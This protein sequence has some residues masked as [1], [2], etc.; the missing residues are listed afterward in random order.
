MQIFVTFS[1]AFIAKIAHPQLSAPAVPDDA[2]QRIGDYMMPSFPPQPS[3]L[4]FLFETR[5]G[6]PE[7]C[8]AAHALWQQGMFQR[9]LVSGGKTGGHARSEAEFI[10]ERL[11]ALGMP[12]S[13]LILETAATNTGENVLLGRATVAEHMDVES[14]RSVLV[15][16]KVCS[17]RR[18]LMTLR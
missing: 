11:L 17:V 15:I 7:F 16:G 3:D 14:I 6:V 13:S 12:A 4:G 18:Y 10:G 5:H 2:Y 9:L 1:P 8:E